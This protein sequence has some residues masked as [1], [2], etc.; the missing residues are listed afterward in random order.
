MRY[1]T[2]AGW[3]ATS[4]AS[5]ARLTPVDCWFEVEEAMSVQCGWMETAPAS[6]KSYGAF[7]LPVI[8]MHYRG[9]DRHPDPLIYF[10]GGPGAPAFLDT[11]SV[12]A[13]WLDWFR[14][15]SGMKRDLVLFDQRGSGMSQ[16]E[17]RCDGY[18]RFRA[19]SLSSPGTPA[20]N[21][22][23]YHATTRQCHDGLQQRGMPLDELGT[24]YSAGDVNDLMTLLGYRNWNLLGVSYG[25]RLAL[26]VQRRYPEKVRSMSLDSVYP[27]DAQLLREWPVLLRASVQR[28]VEYCRQDSYCALENGDIQARYDSLMQQLREQPLVIPVTDSQPG[29]VQELHLNDEILLALLFDAQYASRSLG[30]LAAMLR[31]LQEGRTDRV[32]NHIRDYLRNQFDDSFNE[33]VFWAVECRDNP[34]VSRTE[35]E[36]RLVDFPELSYYLPPEY[37]VCDIWD[38]RNAAVRLAAVTEPRQTPTLILSGKDDPITPTEWAVDAAMREFAQR[39]AHLF[40]FDDISHSVLDNK[41]CA[42]DLLVNFVNNPEQRPS[43]DC[44]FDDF[45]GQ[46]VAGLR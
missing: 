43:A 19:A 40:S 42:N 2:P 1:L 41:S 13:Y 33:A 32:M 25:T 29:D 17:L 5:G 12:E 24:H 46:Q 35:L 4:A 11:V 7:R 45:T 31:H 39:R 27:P 16:P 10:S 30:E 15:K 20:E 8:V 9:L 21:A 44:R 38:T 26:E 36:Q 14:S 34:P 6:G 18:R 37:D 22:H 3:V 23:A 28:L